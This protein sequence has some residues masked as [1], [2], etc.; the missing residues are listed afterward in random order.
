MAPQAT[1]G[2]LHHTPSYD[3]NNEAPQYVLS[4]LGLTGSSEYYLPRRVLS[5]REQEC[6]SWVD[7][8]L[9]PAQPPT[10]L[11]EP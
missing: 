3:L 10:R 2:H 4:P 7:S 6:P 8:E 9:V 5:T 1:W 11:K